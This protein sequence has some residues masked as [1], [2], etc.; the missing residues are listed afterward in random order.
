M[1][2][3]I[4]KPEELLNHLWRCLE[5]EV[6]FESAAHWESHITIRKDDFRKLFSELMKDSAEHKM[7]VESL[8]SMIKTKAGTKDLP[9]RPR[10][11]DFSKMTEVQILAELAGIE[12]LAKTIYKNIREAAEK[13]NLEE[14]LHKDRITEFKT[15][16]DRLISDE[17]IH[18]NKVLAFS[19]DLRLRR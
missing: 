4:A 9:L 2:R 7:M 17:T 18:E 16:L 5:V 13:S 6:V 14:L 11:F 15:T 10:V 12:K 3:R 19:N 8:I 1:A